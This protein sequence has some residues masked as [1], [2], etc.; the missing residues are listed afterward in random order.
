MI[1][2]AGVMKPGHRRWN[3]FL[4]RLE[5]SEGCAFRKKAIAGRPQF[6]WKCNGGKD[7]QKSVEI[8]KKMGG[9]DVDATLRYFEAH[10]GFCD[11]QVLF[12]VAFDH[13]SAVRHNSK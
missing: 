9:V 1:H 5:G 2:N 10:G 3:E 11:C 6:T 13:A 12:N 7:K 8:L 4:T